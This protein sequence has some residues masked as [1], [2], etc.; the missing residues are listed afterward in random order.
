METFLIQLGLPE[1]FAGDI[2]FAFVIIIIG[3][4]LGFLMGRYRLIEL[5]LATYIS[6]AIMSVIPSYMLSFMQ[7]SE[8]LIF[9]LLIISFTMLGEYF[10]DIHLS[11]SSSAF[12]RMSMIGTLETGLIF[13]IL[14]GY[15]P[16]YIL[17]KYIS[18]G[19]YN[20]FTL[21]WAQLFWMIVPL[22]FLF[23]TSRKR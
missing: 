16:G 12:W 11:S 22:L 1:K 5:V 20:F 17:L 8:L 23:V 2:F 3:I 15:I 10:F 19:V 14:I 6:I 4:A 13:S 18:S 7:Y 9:I 21:P